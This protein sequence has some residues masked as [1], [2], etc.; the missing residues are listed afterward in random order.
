M[1][2]QIAALITLSCVHLWVCGGLIVSPSAPTNEWVSSGSRIAASSAELPAL[3][4]SVQGWQRT[5]LLRTQQKLKNL[6]TELRLSR[7]STKCQWQKKRLLRALYRKKRI[8]KCTLSSIRTARFQ[9]K[10]RTGLQKAMRWRKKMCKWNRKCI[11]KKVWPLQ[12]RLRKA[13]KGCD[14]VKRLNVMKQIWR[15]KKIKCGR[16]RKAYVIKAEIKKVQRKANYLKKLLR[17]KPSVAPRP[18]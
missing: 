15:T 10:K 6:Q 7:K 3:H 11:A 4:R 17:P 18:Y 5:V 13:K 2:Y 12:W 8:T 16:Y 14:C 9:C 1:K